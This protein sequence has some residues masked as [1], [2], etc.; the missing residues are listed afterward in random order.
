MIAFV[1]SLSHAQS[2][3]I[4][5]QRFGTPPERIQASSHVA[6]AGDQVRVIFPVPGASAWISLGERD[7]LYDQ[8]IRSARP[9]VGRVNSKA[10]A[11][12]PRL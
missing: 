3:F 12:P 8:A 2:S 5:G 1:D 4:V 6:E 9:D 7:Q 10:R 11:R